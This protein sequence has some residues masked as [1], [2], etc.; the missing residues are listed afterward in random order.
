MQHKQSQSIVKNEFVKVANISANTLAKI[1][2]CENV[3][4]SVYRKLMI[5]MSKEILRNAD[6]YLD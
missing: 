6:L 3:S 2:T 4:F 1:L 5:F